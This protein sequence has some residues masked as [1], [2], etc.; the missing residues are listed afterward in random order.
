V[1]RVP[2]YLPLVRLLLSFGLA[3]GQAE[4]LRAADFRIVPIQ[5]RLSPAGPRGILTLENHSDEA[6]RF[7]VTA[8][9]WDQDVDGK[10]NLV[11]TEDV[12]VFPML[13]SVP[14]GEERKFRV[15]AL[16]RAGAVEK[17]YRVFFDELPPL[18][19]S[20]DVGNKS[21][22]VLTRMGI[23]VF[24]E[25]IK[26]VTQVQLEDATFARGRISFSVQN[27]GTVHATLQGVRVTGF[28]AKGKTMF[29][30]QAE[31]WYLLAGGAR[32][33]E[34]RVSKERCRDVRRLSVEATVDRR[35]ISGEIESAPGSCP[36]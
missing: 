35:T 7:Q 34:F 3:L 9:A 12:R 29:A 24:L 4:A 18:E 31:G 22:R 14:A 21:I 26:A 13:V 11:P 25:P 28:D 2:S 8:F 30:D 19:T 36:F 16:T 1:L 32:R 33:F 27:P 23:P 17:S 6:L 15:I 10:M 5:V 20:A